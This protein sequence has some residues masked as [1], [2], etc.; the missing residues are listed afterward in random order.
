MKISAQ[1]NEPGSPVFSKPLCSPGCQTPKYAPLGSFA[2][3]IVP[4]APTCI[5]SITSS[6]PADLIFSAVAVASGEAKY[7][8]HCD[9]AS[10]PG[11]GGTTAATALPSE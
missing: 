10:P 7:R 9:G 4:K 2:I 11:T 3:S 5:G 8:H 1:A 6:P